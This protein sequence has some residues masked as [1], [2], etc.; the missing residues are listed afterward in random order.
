MADPQTAKLLGGV[1]LLGSLVK[2]K[3]FFQ[4]PIFTD[5]G[6]HIP[7]FIGHGTKDTILDWVTQD[8]FFKKVK[9]AAPDYPIRFDVFVNGLHG[10]PMRLTDWRW[11]LN[12]MIGENGGLASN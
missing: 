4:S 7:I 10:T 9:A 2:D 8:L 11:V 12:W 3:E 1:M 6:R 5:T